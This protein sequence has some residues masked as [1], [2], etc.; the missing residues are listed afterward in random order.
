MPQIKAE[1]RGA[2]VNFMNARGIAHQEETVPAASLKPTQAEFSREKVQKALGYEGGDRS[3]LVSQDG[4]VLDGHHQWMAARAGQGRED[5]P[6]GCAHPSSCWRRP[7][8]PSSSTSGGA[9]DSKTADTGSGATFT[10]SVGT[11]VEITSGLYQGNSGTVESI[12]DTGRVVVRGNN[13]LATGF[14]TTASDLAPSTQQAPT[15][16]VSLAEADRSYSGISRS[17]RSVRGRP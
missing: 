16:A 4:H 6:P 15:S 1:H 3:I 5:D 10:P 14:A 8:I 12:S 17:A 11:A 7:T 9:T 13:S 2:M